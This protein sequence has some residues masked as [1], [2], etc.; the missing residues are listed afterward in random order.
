MA[1]GKQ[2]KVVKESGTNAGVKFKFNL[3]KCCVVFL[4]KERNSVSLSGLS[5]K[6]SLPK[7]KC[8]AIQ[9]EFLKK[10]LF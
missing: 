1:Q 3:R 5:N 4:K 2:K 9:R 7:A 10:N 6:A 8:P